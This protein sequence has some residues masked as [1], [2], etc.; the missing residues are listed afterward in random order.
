[1][2]M[3]RLASP[4]DEERATPLH[5]ACRAGHLLVVQYLVNEKGAELED[6]NIK[7]A[8]ALHFAATSGNIDLV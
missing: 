4:V 3:H 1:M 5:L 6:A 2:Q 8:R 7:G